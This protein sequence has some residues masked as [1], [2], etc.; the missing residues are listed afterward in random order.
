MN[1]GVL[2]QGGMPLIGNS[3]RGRRTFGDGSCSS[4]VVL[5][6]VSLLLASCRSDSDANAKASTT[7]TAITTT[8]ASS[9]QSDVVAAWRRY[10]DVYVAVGSEMRLPD[11]RLAEV[12]TGEELRALGSGFLA[13]KSAGQVIR[14]TIDLA[15]KVLEIGGNR[16]TL[17]DCYASHI[18]RY[19]QASGRPAGT[20]PSERS[21]VTVTMVLEGGSWKVAGIRHEREGCT[22]A[23]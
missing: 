5:V 20:E 12:A 19:D 7:T 14:G 15:P 13:Y 4:A 16:A 10:W 2:Y 22:P 23:A 1:G 3:R 8:T 18:L 6:I 21:L 9:G 11:P 17:T